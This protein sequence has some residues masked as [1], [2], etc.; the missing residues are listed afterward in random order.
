MRTQVPINVPAWWLIIM[1]V[2]TMLLIGV[3][4]LI[5]INIVNNRQK[6]ITKVEEESNNSNSKDKN[7]KDKTLTSWISKKD[8]LYWLLIVCL[9]TISLFT[10]RYKDATEVISHW[11]FAGT[12]V[13]IILAVIAIG[14]TLFQTLTSE[15]SSEK[16]TKSAEKIEDITNK[17]DT[18]SIVKSSEI[19]KDAA[20]YLKENMASIEEKLN[21]INNGQKQFNEF[22]TGFQESSSFSNQSQRVEHFLSLNNFTEKILPGLPRFPKLFVYAY[23]SIFL[24]GKRITE[25]ISDDLT[26]ILTDYD[27]A[28]S[29]S[30]KGKEYI[31]GANMASQGATY[32]FI[33]RLGLVD[34]FLNLDISEK[35]KLIETCKQ[36]I[37]NDEEYIAI[38]D[39]Y[40]KNI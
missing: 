10:F 31:K 25:K 12:I 36:I 34:L 13:S 3:I 17:L 40:I 22:A 20:E 19:M 4:V 21:E 39:N 27:T 1:P 28:N 6:K 8:L 23:F 33:N 32:S 11:G 14:F 37:I 16:I 29:N 7:S 35:Q 18:R 26:Q 24:K 30:L 38:L 9:G 2:L 5:V 15:L